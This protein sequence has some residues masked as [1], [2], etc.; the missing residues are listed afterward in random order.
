MSP[1]MKEMKKLLVLF[2]LVCT[3]F[4]CTNQEPTYTKYSKTHLGF[5]TIIDLTA[6][7]KS[8]EELDTYGQI[9]DKIFVEYNQLFDK[10]HNYEGINNIKTINDSTEGNW[11]WWRL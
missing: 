11:S 3:L 6:Y 4:G 2:I 9:M 5:D 8:Q 10:Y 1:V 7:T